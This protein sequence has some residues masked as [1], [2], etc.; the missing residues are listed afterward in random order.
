MGVL[1]TQ[2]NKKEFFSGDMNNVKKKVGKIQI[3]DKDRLKDK[4]GK[5]D[6]LKLGHHGYIYSNTKDYLN[7]LKPEYAIITNDVG[8]IYLETNQFLDQNNINYLYSTQDEYEVNAI[9]TND[10]IELGFGTQG[11]KNI[12]GKTYYIQEKNIYKNYLNF[13]TNLKYKI[14]EKNVKN[15]DELKK[16]IEDNKNNKELDSNDN[17]CIIGCLKINL[18]NEENNNCY[19]ANSCI[20]INN[21]QNIILTTKE[22]EIII[23]RDKKLFDFPLFYMENSKLILGETNIQGIIKIDGN[24]ENVAANSNLIKLI[25]SELTMHNNIVLCNN[26]NKTTKRTKK[27]PSLN[28]NRFFGSAIYAVYSKINI[29][30]GE[31][32][33]NIHEIFINEKNKESQ[34]PEIIDNDFIYCVR[35]AGIYMNNKCILNMFNGKI[36]NNKGI[37]NSSI[38]SN[39]NSSHLKVNVNRNLHQNCQGIGIFASKNCEIYLHKGE[40]SN[41]TAINN[42]KIFFKTPNNEKIS[43]IFEIYSFIYGAGI[44]SMSSKVEINED[45]IIKNNFCQL[46][47]NINIEKNCLILKAIHSAIRGGH[48]YFYNS[49]CNISGS[50]QNSNN[51]SKISLNIFNKD[52]LNKE[53]KLLIDSQGGGI[54]FINCKKNRN[55]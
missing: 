13:E 49:K 2:G 46:N 9:I 39:I 28:A 12:K 15:W 55:K 17:S 37:N 16:I 42:G 6:L 5:I 41:N 1:L 32:S 36:T 44:Y 24:K 51:N 3:G 27:L 53:K 29:L 33:N 31:I 25:S 45:F 40:I 38:Y 20:T 26:L 52:A 14:I 4:I 34:L 35:G 21:Y 50:I 30:G 18:C 7:K 48:I 43:N 8:E 54:N 47:S 23:K 10:N 11:I 22:K 19:I